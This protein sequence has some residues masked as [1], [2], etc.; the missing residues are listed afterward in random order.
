[1]ILYKQIKKQ[2]PLDKKPTNQKS[3]EF[4]GELTN[5]VPPLN[6]GFHWPTVPLNTE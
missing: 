3:E 2:N 5:N 6:I 4:F 1:L